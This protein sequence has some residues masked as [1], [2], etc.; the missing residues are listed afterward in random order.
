MIWFSSLA[1]FFHCYFSM[2]NSIP[3]ETAPFPELSN[4]TGGKLFDTGPWLLSARRRVKRNMLKVGAGLAQVHKHLLALRR[5]LQ[6]QIPGKLQCHPTRGLPGP[7]PPGHT[8]LGSKPMVRR[9]LQCQLPAP[10]TQG[11]SCTWP[12]VLG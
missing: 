12:L 8:H 11:A 2:N 10:T 7:A 6:A 3:S 4:G 9:W 1:P 5:Y